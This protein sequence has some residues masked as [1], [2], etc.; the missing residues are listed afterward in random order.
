M[1]SK[2]LEDLNNM[3]FVWNAKDFMWY[4]KFNKLRDFHTMHSHTRVTDSNYHC[5]SLVNW[6]QKQHYY[7]KVEERI[8]LLD[9]IA[10]D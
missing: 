7:C 6:V 9:A 10:F 5:K 4:E 1:L 8:K 2:Q 3:G